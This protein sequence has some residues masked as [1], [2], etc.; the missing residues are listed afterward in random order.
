MMINS[1]ND[2]AYEL[3]GPAKVQSQKLL[4]D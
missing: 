3:F 2:W 1:D 4:G